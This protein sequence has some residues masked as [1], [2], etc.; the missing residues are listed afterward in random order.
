M[1]R[2]VR[3]NLAGFG[4]RARIP[5]GR[6]A[7]AQTDSLIG[8]CVRDRIRSTVAIEFVEL[9]VAGRIHSLDVLSFAYKNGGQLLRRYCLCSP[10]VGWLKRLEDS[11]A[12]AGRG[13]VAGDVATFKKVTI[14]AWRRQRLTIVLRSFLHR[15]NIKFRVA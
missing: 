12:A 11:F 7:A 8:G 2:V 6:V 15:L 4:A 1:R 5:D 10:F 3:I 9:C 13:A 14:K